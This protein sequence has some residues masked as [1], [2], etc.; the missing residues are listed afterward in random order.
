MR[1]SRFLLLVALALGTFIPAR[2]A[3]A[4]AQARGSAPT[5]PGVASAPRAR[6]MIVAG[7]GS[8]APG[9]H[10]EAAG[11]RVIQHCLEHA[12]NVP[13]VHA[14]VFYKWPAD[15]AVLDTASA[16]VFIGDT[17]PPMRLPD[18][19]QIMQKLA[20]MMDRGCGL[21]CVHYATGL[22]SE[23]VAADGA[24][25]LLGWL[26][27][28]FLT[29]KVANRSIARVMEAT[30]TP[31]EH[32]HPVLQGCREFKLRDEPYYNNFFGRHGMAKNVTPLATSM[33]PPEAPKREVVAWGIDRQDGGRGVAVVMPHFFRNWQVDDLRRLILN[34]IV[35][36]AKLEVP[37]EGVHSVLPDLATFQQEAPKPKPAPPPEEAPGQTPPPPAAPGQTPNA[38]AAS[39]FQF[40]PVTILPR[41][42]DPSRVA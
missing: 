1:N 8:H 41:P 22:R 32:P 21:V 11:A 20:A 18:R 35:W 14:Q 15:E 6:I 30:I 28:Y 39:R 37:A 31:G 23:D 33:L 19:P 24:H 36:T 38:G 12:S 7:P 5:V 40:Q 26:G 9:T 17:F 3:P 42:W 13:R 27:G 10:E 25:P 2:A 16:I 29:G 4:Q 34:G